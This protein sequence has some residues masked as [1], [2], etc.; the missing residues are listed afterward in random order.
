MKVIVVGSVGGRCDGG[1]C[2]RKGKRT[3]DFA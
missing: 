1:G 2:G 3:S